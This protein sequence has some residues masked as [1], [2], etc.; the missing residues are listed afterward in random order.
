MKLNLAVSFIEI[1]WQDFW[2]TDLAAWL[3]G[4]WHR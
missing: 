1:Y 2:G 3:K 4:E